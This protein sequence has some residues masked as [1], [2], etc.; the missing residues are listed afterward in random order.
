MAGKGWSLRLRWRDE[1]MAPKDIGRRGTVRLAAG[2]LIAEIIPSLGGGMARFDI[3][4]NAERIE[5]FR[6]WP[7][8]GTDDPNTLGLC[9]LVPWSN[10]ISGQGFNF[11]DAFYA[12]LPNFVG[13]P[14]PIH[15]DGW[16]SAWRVSSYGDRYVRLEREVGGPA[17]YC[18]GALLDYAL[19]A[20]GMTIR[21]SATNLAAIALPF[22]LGFHP[23]LPRTPATRLMAR[24]EFVWLEDARHLPTERVAVARR[25]NWDFSSF[26]PLPADWIN[27]GFVGWSGR[28]AIRW[29]DRA[30][31][32]EVEALPPL[33]NF[34]L[35]S[36]SADARF[37]CFE[38]VSHAVDAHNLPPGPE[39]H[40]LVVLAPGTTLAA[41]CRFR[42]RE[43]ES[44]SNLQ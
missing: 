40:G 24:A 37:F 25:P 13:E 38:P 35:Y 29:E 21:L 12:L 43:I 14:C 6:A 27:N 44:R 22:G 33:S 10:R 18:Y 20:D 7:E 34:I 19:D 32:L 9:V 28:A 4:R 23:W 31:A 3:L 1:Q 17:P 5:V 16:L 36:P 26:R 41:E 8:G 30:L 39:A 15:G 42:V 11:G 2:S